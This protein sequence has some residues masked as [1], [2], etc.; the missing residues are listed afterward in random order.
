MS[1]SDDT[2]A[3]KSTRRNWVLEMRKRIKAQTSYGAQYVRDVL[4]DPLERVQLKPAAN[5]SR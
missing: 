1:K 5:T 3:S 4:G 2:S